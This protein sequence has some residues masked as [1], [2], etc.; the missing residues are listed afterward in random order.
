L[1][2]TPEL[3]AA[4]GFTRDKIGSWHHRDLDFD[5]TVTEY[6]DPSGVRLHGLGT[7]FISTADELL[8]CIFAAGIEE[9]RKRS[10]DDFRRLIGLRGEG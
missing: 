3:L 5:G 7:T 10:A 1:K 9:G 2:I 6:D 4:L 8:N